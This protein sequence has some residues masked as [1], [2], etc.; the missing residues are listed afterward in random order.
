[1]KWTKA[2][3]DAIQYDLEAPLLVSAAAGSGKTAVL[4]ER[5][6][7]RAMAGQ[8]DPER[9]LLMTFTEKAAL[10]MRQKLDQKLAEAIQNSQDPAELARLRDLK[11]RFPLAKIST[12]HAFCLSLIREYGAFLTDDREDLI[13]NP[14]FTIMSQAHASIY[15]DQAVDEVLD[16]V[17][18]RLAHRDE[19]DPDLLVSQATSQEA[20]QINDAGET[21]QNMDLINLLDEPVSYRLWL[22]DFANLTFIM[23]QGFTDDKLRESLKNA[24]QK[25]RSLAYY[26]DVIREAL[27]DYQAK[28][29]DFNLLPI[30]DQALNELR[31]YLKPAQEALRE[32]QETNYF[33]ACRSGKLT[34]KEAIRAANQ[35]PAEALVVEKAGEILASTA[36]PGD[37]WDQI[38]TLGQKLGP[39][40]TLK[41]PAKN[42]SSQNSLDKREFME[43]YE[44]G[45]LPLLARI[46]PQFN[47]KS[48]AAARNQLE[49]V[50]SLFSKS[51]RGIAEDMQKMVGPLAR[52]Y[53]LVLLVDR[54]MQAIKLS[55]NKIDFNDF[56]HYALRLLDQEEVA[57]Q[58]RSYYQEVYLDEYQDTNP[59]QETLVQRLACP[60]TF[61]VGDLKQSIYRF[62]HADPDIFREKL[63]SYQSYPA[64]G[65]DGSTGGNLI[66]LNQNFRSLSPILDGINQLFSWFMHREYAEIEYDDRQALVA[67]RLLK[68]NGGE[69]GEGSRKKIEFNHLLMAKDFD[70]KEIKALGRLKGIDL[71]SNSDLEIAAEA[72]QAVIEIQ[73][74]LKAGR[75]YGD[76]AILART[77][78]V[79]Q[80]YAKVL[81]AFNLPTRGGEGKNYLDSRELSFLC[82]VMTLL[83]NAK[84]D[85]PLVALMRSNLLG[86][87]FTEDDLL[88]L[89]LAQADSPF[90]YQIVYQLAGLD[91]EK[92]I[93][94]VS[95]AL[96]SDPDRLSPAILAQLADLRERLKNFCDL[97]AE[98]RDKAK[99]LP[100]PELLDYIF[101][102]NHYPDY[103][104]SL[105]FAE[106]RL[107]DLAQFRQ[108]ARQFS[109]EQGGTLN[110]FVAFIQKIL[111]KKL[112]LENF[113][114][115][116]APGNSIALMTIHASKGL[117][118]PVVFLAGANLKLFS[119]NDYPIFDFDPQLGL[120]AYIADG[121]TNTIHS[122]PD[123]LD[124]QA[125]LLRRDWAEQYR[126]LYVAMTR[127][128]DHLII[129]SGARMNE[130]DR[131]RLAKI[132]ANLR[133]KMGYEQLKKL[134]SYAE[135]LMSC[136]SREKAEITDYF[137]GAMQVESGRKELEF[138]HYRASIVTAE[139]LLE[140][141]QAKF[142]RQLEDRPAGQKNLDDIDQ[143]GTNEGGLI[144]TDPAS[145]AQVE[146]LGVLLAKWPAEDLINQ[147]PAKLTVS[148]LKESGQIDSEEN[149]PRLVPGLVDMAFN[150]RQPQLDLKEDRPKAQPKLSGPEFGSLIHSLMLYLPLGKF[151]SCDR[152]EWQ[153]IFDK[154]ISLMIQQAKLAGWQKDQAVAAYPLIVGFLKS[155]LAQRIYRLEKA[156]GPVYREVPFTLAIP[157]LGL[158]HT[159][160]GNAKEQTL[161]Q[162]MIDLWFLEDGQAVLL[163]YKSDVIQGSY[164]EKRDTLRQRYQVQLDYYSLAIQRIMG[165]KEPVKER[166]IWLFRDRQAY[167]L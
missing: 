115:P 95:K 70:S 76:F 142:D 5:I 125:E 68:Q 156:G 3:L 141:V 167:A 22:D 67:G 134:N 103:L 83:D 119:R 96:A 105:A 140:Q 50:N 158:D 30:G 4:I 87:A 161:V 48:A 42:S 15:L 99:W 122:T 80:V 13:L 55:H 147:S 51:S 37:K 79:C 61:M 154:E 98:L 81:E 117:E 153:G 116:P 113:A 162:G 92:F 23:D 160:E 45:V 137:T 9:I 157:A 53:E 102:I 100:L 32:A 111:D 35:V 38:H 148:E 17:Y 84:Q 54:R 73:D 64:P 107:K 2:Q 31:V 72:L 86:P 131:E 138:E 34:T 36:S 121:Q 14:G 19:F 93:E 56:E 74:G 8:L 114:N 91:N 132:T 123:L 26:F 40:L 29:E 110:N 33:R 136:L 151:L 112:E 25:L 62:R 58:V 60:R 47:R 101:Q 82:Q 89:R 164:Q 44:S 20:A 21:G 108:W 63:D 118:F 24:W 159:I 75:T 59:I 150:I 126:L 143:A 127:A 7:R 69:E 90:F 66:L 97:L 71:T 104:A 85:I 39:P 133:A 28:A 1:M 145:L 106:E 52:F 120:S 129:L 149:P 109:Q 18:G 128:E 27:A 135:I 10:Q 49:D 77:N 94:Q 166:L 11:R 16:F 41:A 46:N 43:S 6:F 12:I 57:R 163:D 124:Q 139:F 146:R 88:L 144:L 65:L 78:R 155:D 165:L 152:A 130:N